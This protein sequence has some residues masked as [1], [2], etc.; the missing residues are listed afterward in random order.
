MA[1]EGFTE[2]EKEDRERYNKRRWWLE[3]T[4]GDMFDKATDIYP[5]KIGLVDGIGRWT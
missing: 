5:E 3:M 2:Y 1:V 4:W